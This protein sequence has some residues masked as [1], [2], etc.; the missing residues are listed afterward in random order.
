MFD[1]EVSYAGDGYMVAFG[2]RNILDE[3]Q[4]KIKSPTTAVG[5]T[6]PQAA[7]YPAGW[8]RL[9]V[10]ETFNNHL[11]KKRRGLPPFFGSKIRCR[12]LPLV[13]LNF[14]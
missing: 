1:M 14:W 2:G 9:K 5:A 3:Y 10:R 8:I 6:I 11:V 12:R 13:E 7:E 4:I